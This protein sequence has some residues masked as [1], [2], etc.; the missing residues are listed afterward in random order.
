MEGNIED[1]INEKHII[2]QK[3]KGFII[4]KKCRFIGQEKNKYWLVKNKETDEE[5]YMMDVSNNRLALID[6]NSI[7]KVLSIGKSWTVCNNYVVC[8]YET[9]KKIAM[10][11]YLME[12][13]GHGLTKGNLTVDHINRNKLDNRLCN[14]RITTQ[15]VQNSNRPYEKKEDSKYNL[16]RPEGMEH[17]NRLPRN[18]EFICGYRIPKKEKGW[19]LAFLVNHPNCPQYGKKRCVVST[20]SNDVPAIEKYNYILDKMKE[21]DIPII[22]E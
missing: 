1:I 22:Y 3:F 16:Q 12:H 6:K 13:S 9:D 14:L 10:H 7:E 20:K 17:I 19:Y 18:V 15:S 5:Y 8:E 4:T 21:L 11:A 2:I